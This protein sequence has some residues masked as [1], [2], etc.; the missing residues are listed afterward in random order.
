MFYVGIVNFGDL[1]TKGHSGCWDT[2]DFKVL[3]VNF[4]F[5]PWSV[6]R[7]RH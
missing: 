1:L 3:S 5:A 6:G 4:A 2:D 7:F